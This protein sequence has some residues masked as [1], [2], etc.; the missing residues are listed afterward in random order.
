MKS[1]GGKSIKIT[2]DFSTKTLYARKE[3]HE[4]HKVLNGNKIFSQDYSIQKGYY[5]E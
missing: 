2:E 4:I 5:S 1:Q 3:W